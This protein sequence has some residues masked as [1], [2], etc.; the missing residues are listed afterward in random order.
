MYAW[1]SFFCIF[2]FYIYLY[3]MYF[4]MKT[5]WRAA[6]GKAQVWIIL[7]MAKF[8]L[9]AP[10]LGFWYFSRCHNL[11]GH[12]KKNRDVVNV[13]I[14]NAWAVPAMTT[15][16][17]QFL[18]FKVD[19]VPVTAGFSNKVYCASVK[20]LSLGTQPDHNTESSEVSFVFMCKTSINQMIFACVGSKNQLVFRT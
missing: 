9:A 10:V 5:V 4:S 1:P 13:V 11:L 8:H 15:Q 17:I 18:L 2:I 7:V 19:T 16:K 6:V 3:F 12:L 20:R 14:S